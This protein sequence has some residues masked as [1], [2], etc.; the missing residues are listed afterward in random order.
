[1]AVFFL[2]K[3]LCQ[4]FW[5]GKTAKSQGKTEEKTCTQEI[6]IAIGT[7]ALLFSRPDNY[8]DSVA[9]EKCRLTLN[10]QGLITVRCPVNFIRST[11]F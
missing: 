11:A 4:S 3:N 10:R 9:G 8:R 7:V 5:V 2:L 1:M 6:P